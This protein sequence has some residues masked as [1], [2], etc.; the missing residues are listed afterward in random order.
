MRALILIL[1][2]GACSTRQDQ[3]F[4]EIQGH[5]GARGV[6]PENSIPAFLHALDVGAHTLEMDVVVSKDGELVVSH[7]PYF[8]PEICLDTLGRELPSDTV[9]NIYAL[10]YSVISKFDCGSIG[11]SRF[12]DQDKQPTNKP[13]LKDVL[14]EA[15]R[16]AQ[17]LNRK[18][19]LYNIELKTTVE[20]DTIFH[21]VPADFSEL[22]FEVLNRYDMWDRITIQS[23]D[24]RT[25]QY[26][27][28]NYPE[29]TL[30]LLVENKDPWR[31]NLNSLG[32][33]PAIYS[34]HYK[35][36]SQ[37]TIQEIQEAGMKVIPW[38][39]NDSLDIQRLVN[40]K[41]DGI[42]SDYPGRAISILNK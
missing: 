33:V 27:N 5:R 29:L 21:P 10:D 38:T 4:V 13:R 28:E 18:K 36:L 6:L 26:F 1:I 12:P 34:C 24:F 2:L 9:I 37:Q 3:H 22:V 31:Q 40:W 35:L 30:A 15:E 23:F 16:Y 41:V 25:L 32:F 42:I 8:L 17:I 19:P 14:D 7:E 11:N 39:V 20:T